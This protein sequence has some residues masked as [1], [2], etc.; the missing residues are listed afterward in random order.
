MTVFSNTSFDTVNTI[1]DIEQW[2][3]LT[4]YDTLISS[5][6]KLITLFEEIKNDF[7]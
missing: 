2:S 3:I 4:M 5:F 1:P 6:Y 7:G